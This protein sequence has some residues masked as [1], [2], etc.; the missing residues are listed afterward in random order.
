MK[1]D[2][3]CDGCGSH[4]VSRDAGAEWDVETQNWVLAAVYDHAYCHEC[5][6]ST[7]LEEVS[8]RVSR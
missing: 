2:Y 4:E 6:K 7:W 5:R 8:V 1:V 3:V